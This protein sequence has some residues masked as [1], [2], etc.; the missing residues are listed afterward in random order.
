MRGK[1]GLYWLIDPLDGTKEFIKEMVE[2]T[3]KYSPNLEESTPIFGGKL[4]S[5]F[6]TDDIYF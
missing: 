3:V 4:C 6:G 2:F 5:Q 1:T